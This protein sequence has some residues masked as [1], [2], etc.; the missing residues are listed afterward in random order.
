[1]GVFRLCLAMAVVFGHSNHAVGW[2]LTGPA[3]VQAFFV[4]SG[5]Y[6]ALILDGKYNN[7]ALFYQNRF[8]RLFPSYFLIVFLAIVT[9]VVTGR[10]GYYGSATDFIHALTAGDSG[11]ALSI[12]F[13][14]LA[15]VGQEISL[16]VFVDGSH[17]QFTPDMQ[18]FNQLLVTFLLVPQAWSISLEIYFYLLAPF[19][20]RCST[21]M[22]TAMLLA[23]ISL[24]IILSFLGCARDP[25]QNR[26]FPTSIVFFVAGLLSY[27]LYRRLSTHWDSQWIG[28]GRIGAPARV[29]RHVPSLGLPR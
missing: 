21:K 7:A 12:I 4:I 20:V 16:F 8:L 18:P 17:L 29:C 27:R 25:W 22:L 26:F 13:M 19:I 11:Q 6:M 3:R 23:S 9:L 2:F 28:W 24:R 15:I 1:M 10:G 14:N 5:F